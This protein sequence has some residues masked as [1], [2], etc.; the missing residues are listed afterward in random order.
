MIL[1]IF[2]GLV[3]GQEK[4][5]S[6]STQSSAKVDHDAKK[7]H[8]QKDSLT[9]LP[10]TIQK[11]IS[12][13][14][15]ESDTIPL[16]GDSILAALPD[17]IQKQISD[18]VA[19]GDSISMQG[20]SLF[21]AKDTLFRVVVV[22]LSDPLD[23]ISNSI[24]AYRILNENSYA[25][26][27]VEIDTALNRFQ[28]NN[29]VMKNYFAGAYLGNAGLSYY[30]IGFEKRKRPSDFLFLDHVSDYLHIP[31]EMTYYRTKM[32]YT[33]IDYSSAGAKSENES[34]FKLIH[35]QNINKDWN[36][37]LCYD[38]VSS[39][40][41]YASQ[42]ASDNALSLFTAYRSSQYSIHANFTWNNVRMKEN[43][44]LANLSE[45]FENDADPGYY[46]VRSQAGKTILLNRSL[47][48]TQSYSLKKLNFGR[49]QAKPDTID[50]SRFT[51]VQTFKYEW[52]KREFF[53]TEQ[54]AFAGKHEPYF[55]TRATHD[56][57]YF[58]RVFN[59]FELMFKEQ[60][61][62]KFTAGFSVGILNELDRYNNNI[63]PKSTGTRI[64]PYDPTNTGWGG[65][66]PLISGTD[67]TFYHRQTKKYINTALTGRFFNHT[68][69]YLNWDFNGRLYLTGYKL[70]N[71]NLNGTVQ[72][73]YY[74]STGRNTLLLG[75]SIDNVRPGYFLNDYA[76][77]WLAW[78]NDFDVSQEVRLRGEF[79]IPNRKLKLGAYV[80]Q[81]NNYVFIN[82]EA[83]PE[84]AEYPMVTGTAY[85]EKDIRWW[86]FGFMF[87]LYGQYSSHE[88][89]IPLPAFAGYQSTYFETWL[90][91]KVLIMRLGWD[92]NY[93]SAYYAYAYMPSSGMFYVQEE[94]K[95]GNYPFF[96]AFL[97][98]QI[99]RARIF[100]KTEGLNTLFNNMLGKEYF[101]VYRYPLTEMRVKF[102]VS[103]A[104]YD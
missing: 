63:I 38:V 78:N 94:Q 31:E 96:D 104:F 72:V 10:D 39:V 79:L 58:R 61:R 15:A 98:L 17:T 66:L 89:I 18:I 30:P 59:H 28:V 12:N 87:R 93:N 6:A 19:E 14:I 85:I 97:N 45:F 69:R 8:A 26:L 92:I 2:S 53:D 43:G 90:V 48:L 62:N 102:G 34:I 20:D 29:P 27:Q 101:M 16:P 57:L 23:T 36:V 35:T 22:G 68:G 40:G 60:S 74:T 77:N 71:V 4:A 50:V 84:Q 51:L 70:G 33:H 76:S 52:N 91:P 13:I 25:R 47:Y 46:S 81:L 7:S 42:N 21:A 99:N 55:G 37:G 54:Y 49:T 88:K 86:K 9:I 1:T 100:I 3:S 67:T 64:D 95:L 24:L 75:G 83:V 5:S 103:W 65:D 32:P 82:S 56:S 41:Q 73:H 44:G 11:R 80:S